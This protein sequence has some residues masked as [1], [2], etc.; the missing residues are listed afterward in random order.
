[1]LTYEF[2]KQVVVYTAFTLI[3]IAGIGGWTYWLCE[4]FSFIH[5]KVK[6]HRAK[7]A[8]DQTDKM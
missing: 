3:I 7:R 1:M 4:I 6:A 5:K 2:M 8:A